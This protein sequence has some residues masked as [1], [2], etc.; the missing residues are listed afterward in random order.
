MH[1]IVLAL[2]CVVAC[3]MA[4][5]APCYT[6]G[7]AFTEDFGNYTGT[8]YPCG[9]ASS[10]AC[11]NTWAYNQGSGATITSSQPGTGWL[12]TNTLKVP[13]NA[14]Q[15][16]VYTLGSMQLI[17]SGQTTD[18][19]IEFAY[20]ATTTSG[21][22]LV[23][24]TVPASGQLAYQFGFWNTTNL[25]S[26]GNESGTQT[27]SVNTHHLLQ[28]HL[29][30][31]SSYDALDGGTHYTFTAPSY[32]F[33][34]IILSGD[35]T[36]ANLYY[37]NV[38]VNNSSYSW[39]SPPPQALM[40]GAGSPSGTV[41][42]AQMNSATHGGNSVPGW[43]IV[44]LSNLTFTWTSGGSGF[45]KSLPVCGSSYP[46]TNSELIDMNLTVNASEGGYLSFPLK[47]TFNGASAGYVFSYSFSGLNTSL[48]TF[49]FTDGSGFI[50]YTQINNVAGSE[51]LVFQN[52]SGA[53]SAAV[54]YNLSASTQYFAQSNVQV[55]CGTSCADVLSLYSFP[56]CVLLGTATAAPGGG[57]TGDR[58]FVPVTLT[59][60]VG[61]IGTDAV[62]N[63]GTVAY[64]NVVM[65]LTGTLTPAQMCSAATLVNPPHA[66]FSM[67][68]YIPEVEDAMDAE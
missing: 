57:Q 60:Q 34:S 15:V 32:G 29:A 39:C 48:D 16:Q 17:P 56:A 64:S 22:T 53:S 55:G 58:A 6:S 37:G 45:G 54:N 59:I 67:L 41:T 1:K 23:E 47:T 12:C 50:N 9:V 5:A 46:G 66:D 18:I 36:S 10:S 49:G 3:S 40:D 30:G 25:C 28:I 31:A 14:T 21:Q 8:T 63:T 26:S 44:G 51:Q 27:C 35:S 62:A 19:F 13:Q 42:A 43:S 7:T 38:Y 33:D 68:W 24:V 2:A 52:A 65:D 20:D 11:G 61:K 4:W